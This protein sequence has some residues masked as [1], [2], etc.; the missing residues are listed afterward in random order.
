MPLSPGTRLGP[1][2]VTAKIGEG[3]MGEVWQAT[4]AQLGRQVSISCAMGLP[5]ATRGG[6]GAPIRP[7]AIGTPGR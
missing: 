4:D 1:Y 6:A 3:G 7:V 2:S 5:L